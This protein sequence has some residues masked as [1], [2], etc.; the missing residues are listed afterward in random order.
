MGASDAGLVWSGAGRKRAAPV[1]RLCP[2]SSSRFFLGSAF[3]DLIEICWAI[4][5]ALDSVR[6]LRA[7]F[8]HPLWLSLSQ[9]LP[10]MIP[11]SG[12]FFWSAPARA[13]LGPIWRLRLRLGQGPTS[14]HSAAR[15]PA[16]GAHCAWVADS[17]IRDAESLIQTRAETKGMERNGQGGVCAVKASRQDGHERQRRSSSASLAVCAR[18]GRTIKFELGTRT[19]RTR[20][21]TTT[22]QCSRL[23]DLTLSLRRIA[24]HNVTR[25]VVEQQPRPIRARR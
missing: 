7:L 8:W 25:L 22:A 4:A 14:P 2:S 1:G 24:P 3:L 21:T 5:V 19:L 17:P 11:G 12:K 16:S 20:Y 15:A 6:A 13:L 23:G 18:A 10:E 9:S